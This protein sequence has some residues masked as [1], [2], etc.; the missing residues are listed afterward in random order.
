M[1]PDYASIVKALA[2]CS[3][4]PG[5]FDKRF[6]R[7]LDATRYVE[8]PQPLTWKQRKTIRDLAQKYRRQLDPKIVTLASGLEKE[9]A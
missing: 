2:G 8:F 7:D 9:P 6:V 4:T 5:S 3:M 1:S